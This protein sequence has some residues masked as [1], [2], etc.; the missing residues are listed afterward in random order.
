MIKQVLNKAGGLLGIWYAVFLH[1]TWAVTLLFTAQAAHSTALNGPA[2]LFPNRFGLALLLIVVAGSAVAG[3]FLRLGIPKVL[4]LVPQQVMLGLSA[5]SAIYAIVVG[6]Y[7]DGTTR[8][9]AFILADQVPA[10]LALLVHSLSILYVTAILNGWL[11]D[12]RE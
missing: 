11:A 7:A 1:L 5:G 6:H 2:T 3:V 9:A 10:V 4:L 8:S 12:A